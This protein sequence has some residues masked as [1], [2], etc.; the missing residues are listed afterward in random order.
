[1]PTNIGC[2]VAAVRVNVIIGLLLS[3][4]A[5]PTCI[6]PAFALKYHAPG[7]RVKRR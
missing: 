4:G 7:A 6:A 3:S 1:M 2:I 5:M